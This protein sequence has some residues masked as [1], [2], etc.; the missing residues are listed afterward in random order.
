MPLSLKLRLPPFVIN[1]QH[2]PLIE[3]IPTK[4]TLLATV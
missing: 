4:D 2:Q 1:P 3:S